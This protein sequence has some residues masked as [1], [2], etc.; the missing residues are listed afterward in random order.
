MPCDD[1]FCVFPWLGYSV[2]LLSQTVIKMLLWT[3][4]VAV[5]FIN[6]ISI[7]SQVTL[8]KADYLPLHG[9]D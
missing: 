7:Y 2:Q 8:S 5:D 6:M 3:I 4:P 9:W 1:Y